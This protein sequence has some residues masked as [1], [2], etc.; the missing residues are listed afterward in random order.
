LFCIVCS[1]Q[2]NRRL[3]AHGKISPPGS[4]FFHH[5]DPI[6][7]WGLENLEEPDSIS[8]YQSISI[9]HN[10]ATMIYVLIYTHSKPYSCATI[11][12]LAPA[13]LDS[14]FLP[15][16]DSRTLLDAVGIVRS[17]EVLPCIFNNQSDKILSLGFIQNPFLVVILRAKSTQSILYERTVDTFGHPLC[18]L[19]LPQAVPMPEGGELNCACSK[20]IG[21]RPRN[22]D[23]RR[24]E[25]LDSHDE[26]QFPTWR[27]AI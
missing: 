2:H 4:M 25:R 9:P 18:S 13:L 22:D 26:V 1:F 19:C 11:V 6:E 17:Q 8:Y 14:A 20:R 21:Q 10:L 23:L 16:A 24:V 7:L 5:T 3:V 27:S 15:F 12:G